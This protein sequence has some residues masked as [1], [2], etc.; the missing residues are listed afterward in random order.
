MQW[1]WFSAKP[2]HEKADLT[3]SN[4]RQVLLRRLSFRR[5]KKRYSLSKTDW[6]QKRILRIGTGYL[7]V[8]LFHFVELKGPNMYPKIH[9]RWQLALHH[10]VQ[11]LTSTCSDDSHSKQE[12]LNTKLYSPP[13]PPPCDFEVFINCYIKVQWGLLSCEVSKICHY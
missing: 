3:N 7:T 8:L 13:P 4:A 11:H 6:M 5:K 10:K 1:N 2:S 9:H 12:N